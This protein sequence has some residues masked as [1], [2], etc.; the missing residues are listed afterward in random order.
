M[1][2][3]LLEDCGAV[4]RTAGSAAEA[5]A[6]IRAACR[7]A[8]QRHRHARRGRVRPDPPGA[9]PAR[10]RRRPGPAVALTAY[11]RAADRVRALEAGFQMHLSKPVDPAELVVTVAALA[12]M[13]R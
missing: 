4:V 2:K 12:R 1:V 10:R 3:R 5:V 13:A 6:L 8:G 11:A 7:R 9:G